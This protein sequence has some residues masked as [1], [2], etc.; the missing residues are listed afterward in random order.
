LIERAE[1]NKHNAATQVAIIIQARRDWQSF[2]II[3]AL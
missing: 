1:A 3:D 2:I